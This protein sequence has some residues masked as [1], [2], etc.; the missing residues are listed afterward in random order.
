MTVTLFVPTSPGTLRGRLSAFFDSDCKLGWWL[1][2]TEKP[3]ELGSA[4]LPVDFAELLHSLQV[5][6]QSGNMVVAKIMI[7]ATLFAWTTDVSARLFMLV[8]VHQ[9]RLV[10][11]A[12]LQCSLA[13]VTHMHLHMCC[14]VHELVCVVCRLRHTIK[15]CL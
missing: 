5:A 13:C 10:W 2:C 11:Y 9:A 1:V 6:C 3:A 7:A 12:I 15:L 8:I 4:D 14:G